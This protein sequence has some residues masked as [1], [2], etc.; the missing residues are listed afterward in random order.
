[1]AI[2]QLNTSFLN[3]VYISSHVYL[4]FEQ[5][6]TPIIRNLLLSKF[7]MIELLY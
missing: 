6:K 7:P 2:F 1:M 4:I 5:K 3:E